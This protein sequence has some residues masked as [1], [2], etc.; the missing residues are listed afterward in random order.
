[1]TFVQIE[2]EEEGRVLTVDLM[3][4]IIL[5]EREG[6]GELLLDFLRMWIL[7]LSDF[8][9]GCISG[10]AGIYAALLVPDKGQKSDEKTGRKNTSRAVAVAAY[11][12][13]EEEKRGHPSPHSDY[14]VE[15]KCSRALLAPQLEHHQCN[16]GHLMKWNTEHNATISTVGAYTTHPCSLTRKCEYVVW[17]KDRIFSFLICL[18]KKEYF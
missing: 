7:D 8:V 16:S 4:C 3:K 9:A 2:E 17:K 14:W 15:L 6:G 5:Q 18:R 12:Q 11:I 13:Q 1:M 10:M